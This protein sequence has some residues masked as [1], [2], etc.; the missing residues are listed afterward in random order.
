MQNRAAASRKTS[1]RRWTAAR[2][3]AAAAVLIGAFAML[4]GG[5]AEANETA[6]SHRAVTVAPSLLERVTANPTE[7]VEAV[8]TTWR[9]EGLDDVASIVQGAKLRTLPMV[10]TKSLTLAQLEQLKASGV[11]R[12]VYPNTK[13]EIQ[14]EDTTWITKA[15]YVWSSSNPGGPQG[16]GVRGNNVELAVIDTGIDGQHEDADNLV[17]FCETEGAVTG[18]RMEVMCSPYDPATGNVAPAPGTCGLAAFLGLTDPDDC[19]GTG[20]NAARMD[21]TDDDGHGSHVSGTVAGTGHASGG[22]VNTH[23]TIGM[24]PQARLRVYSANV[25]PALINFEILAAFDDLTWKKENGFNDVVAVNNSWGGGGGSNYDPEDPQSIAFKRAYDAG[26]LP[27]FAA[28]NSGHEHDTLSGQC[29]SP[30]VACVAASTKPDSIVMFSSRG[31]PSQPTDTNRDGEITSADVEPDNHDRRLAQALDLGVYRP[32]LAAPGVNINSISANSAT[33]REVLTMAHSGCYEQLNGT[34]MASP[35]VTGAVGLIVQ[36]YRQEHDG[37]TPSPAQIIDILERSANTAKLPAWDTEE[38]GAGRLD[39]HQAV[40]QARGVVNLPRPNFGHPTP[41]YVPNGYPEG[42]VGAEDF[43]G[44]TAAGS[45]TAQGTDAIPRYGQHFI[46]VAPKTER[47]RITIRWN[48]LANH[49]VRLWRPGINPNADTNPAGPTRAFPDNESVGLLDTDSLP[50]LGPERLIEIRS[51][52]AGTWTM[53][54]YNRV[55][56]AATDGCGTTQET[57]QVIERTPPSGH[58]YDVWVEKPLVTHQPSVIIDSPSGNTTG[59]FVEVRGR[60][61][62]PPHA[63]DPPPI[64]NVGHS[65]EGVTNWEV[66]G[67]SGDTGGGGGGEPD[68][69]DRPVLYFHTGVP[70]DPDPSCTRQG[71]LDVAIVGCGPYMIESTQLSTQVPAKF[72]PV[73]PVINGVA[74]RNIYDPNFTWCL[75]I[76]A[77]CSVVHSPGPKT[78]SGPMTVEW[79]ASTNPAC[80]TPGAFTMGWTIRLWA[81]GALKFQS[82]RIEA[83]PNICLVPTRLKAVVFVPT[84]TAQQRFVVQ[85]DAN[86]LDVDQEQTF[87]YYDS[88]GAASTICTDRGTTGAPAAGLTPPTCDSLVKMPVITDGGG[89]G[90]GNPVPQNVRV[91]DLPAGAPYPGAPQT[92]ALRVAW[93]PVEGAT[94]YEVYRSTNP[95]SLGSRVFRGAGTLCTSPEAP[96][97]DTPSPTQD[98]PPGHDRAGLCFTNT[99]VSLLTTYYYRVLSRAANGERSTLSNIAYGTPTRY[100]RQVKLR[101]DRLYGPQHWEYA[102][103]SPSPT[104]SDTQNAG[105]RWTFVWDTLELAAGPHAVSARSFTQGIG[106]QK[107]ERTLGN[108]EDPPPPPPD[109]GCPD[110]DDGDGDDD[111][112]D[113]DDD[114]NGDDDDD[115]CEDDDDEEEDEDD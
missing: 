62:Y 22:T 25:G 21:S 92:P 67:S 52:E 66:P 81:D 74:D 112:E 70:G 4:G 56:D 73:S 82:S 98:A 96:G 108:D 97:T 50:F 95:L 36:A 111:E 102:L 99:G 8:I 38:Q 30:W 86:E 5:T 45:W 76:G 106:S 57:P 19:F 31:R 72:G 33:C 91:T 26:I 101:V 55:P 20:M 3:I 35:H 40:R 39:V 41:P 79:W 51:P 71:N 87:V 49:Y 83:T 1:G 43:K 75:A 18:S 84:T 37:D 17:E 29:V 7:G 69:D 64:N 6:S 78:V 105:T 42:S 77:G 114:D 113:G 100:D 47:L 93:D 58:D 53:R 85:I 23:S 24:S 63:S 15:R 115:D 88:Q 80:T 61:G 10:L 9:R 104:P 44:C 109:G 27:V 60:A 46:S 90:G 16:F 32:A 68:P 65:W 59:R 54:V 110:D 107:A 94:Q 48:E 12:S 34:S 13:Y 28:G 14:M 11:V 2:P 89:G 103:A